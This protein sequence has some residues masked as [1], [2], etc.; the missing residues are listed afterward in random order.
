MCLSLSYF[1]TYNRW[2][3]CHDTWGF[4]ELTL[5]SVLITFLISK[6]NVNLHFLSHPPW[7]ERLRMRC[8]RPPVCRP[9]SVS[10]VFASSLSKFM[11][12]A[13]RS[14]MANVALAGASAR[15]WSLQTSDHRC[16][17]VDNIQCKPKLFPRAE[18][19]LR[20]SHSKKNVQ[21]ESPC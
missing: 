21:T 7:V 19:F 16:D 4:S 2:T 10:Y 15:I 1:L 5:P 6:N 18:F 12:L 3:S 8:P 13:P 17:Y 9:E 14:A 20:L 11:L